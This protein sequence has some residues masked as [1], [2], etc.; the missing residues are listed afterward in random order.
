LLGLCTLLL[1]GC[2]L[3]SN[4][5]EPAVEDVQ[6][7]IDHQTLLGDAVVTENKNPKRLD[8][9][10]ATIGEQAFE[11]ELSDD[12]D[13]REK[14]LMYRESMLYNEGMLFIFD[15]VTYHRFWMKNTLIPLDILWLDENK[16]VVDFQTASP[17]YKDPCEIIS[18]AAKA[19]YVIELPAGSFVESI[20]TV[21]DF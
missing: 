17:C 5:T 16:T 1:L 10:S 3:P 9:V 20:G 15:T 6:L 19:K 21:V 12:P 8:S 7:N 13:S 2:S 14:G 4:E 11:L 18:P